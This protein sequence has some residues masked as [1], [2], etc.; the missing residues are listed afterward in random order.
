MPHCHSWSLSHGYAQQ[1]TDTHTHNASRGPLGPHTVRHSPSPGSPSPPAP[2]QPHSPRGATGYGNT[3]GDPGPWRHRV[4]AGGLRSASGAL[5]QLLSPTRELPAPECFAAQRFPLCACASRCAA[6]ARAQG[7]VS[8]PRRAPGCGLVCE[9]MV[10]LCKG[11]TV[12]ECLPV[13]YVLYY[14]CT[15]LRVRTNG[16]WL[17]SAYWGSEFE[18]TALQLG[19]CHTRL[20]VTAGV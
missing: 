20:G 18:I 17:L 14:C 13:W 3:L 5:N 12:I 2:A 10:R 15:P 16:G 19:V 9:A 4:R 6:S 8:R 1:H 7:T 11:V